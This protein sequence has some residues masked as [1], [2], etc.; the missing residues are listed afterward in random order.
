MPQARLSMRKITEVFRLKYEL[1]RS[2]REIAVSCAVGLGTVSE[3]LRRAKAAGLSWPLP[4]GLSEAELEGLLFPSPATP[5]KSPRPLP[6]WA[7]VARQLKR[8]GVTL[9]L[10]WEEY[11]ASHPEGYGYSAFC[12]RYDAWRGVSDLPMHQDHKAGE[13]L[14]VD[15]AGHTMPVVDRKTGEV[16]QAQIFVAALGASS[17]IYAEATWGQTVPDW[18]AAHVR[19]FAFFGGVPVVVVPDNLKSGVRS[20]CLYQP[21]LNPTYQDLARHYRV[22]IIPTR[23]R[24]PKDKAKVESA[25]QQVERWVLAPLRDVTF[26]SLAELNEALDERVTWLNN[27]PGQGLP[28]SRRD[29]FTTLDQPALRPL[30][31]Q[32]YC[33]VEWRKAKVNIGYHVLADFHYYSVPYQHARLQ[34]DIR[35]TSTT[36]EVYLR[37]ERIA[38]HLR[39]SRRYGYTSLREHMPTYHQA[40]LD[41]D[42]WT[43]E[44]LIRWARTTGPSTAAVIQRILDGGDPVQ[45]AFNPCLGVM[46]LGTQKGL[47]R[48]EAACRYALVHE[49]VSYR[50]IKHILA[51]N[52]AAPCE[53]ALPEPPPIQHGNIRG[54]D[55]YDPQKGLTHAAAPDA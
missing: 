13:K 37:G 4:A 23:V 29:L 35:L 49:V 48:L 53:E 26:F 39:S 3:Y 40:Q 44:R 18:I 30:P 24:K 17:Y 8:K 2:Q 51:R 55:Y 36:V 6:D 32:P 19:A 47:D 45:Q 31:D 43:P 20:P 33:L 52:L 28:A 41:R 12:Q 46:R 1:G 5:S 16:R 9:L 42:A 25:V 22:A 38:S 34:V 7:E 10:L 15:Y 50:S 14:F 11:R 54:A 21:D 27:R